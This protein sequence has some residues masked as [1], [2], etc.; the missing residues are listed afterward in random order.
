[1]KPK[2]RTQ[3]T[4]SSALREWA[5]QSGCLKEEEGE[6]PSL[7]FGRGAQGKDLLGRDERVLLGAGTVETSTGGQFLEEGIWEGG[8]CGRA[9]C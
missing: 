2:A 8:V 9:A 7:D 6:E 5:L 1:M 4:I 3:Q